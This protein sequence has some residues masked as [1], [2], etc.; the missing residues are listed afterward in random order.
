MRLSQVTGTVR[1][2]SQEFQHNLLR[3]LVYLQISS[4]DSPEGEL[5]AQVSLKN[6]RCANHP[7]TAPP[8]KPAPGSCLSEGQHYLN[9]EVWKPDYDQTCT[10]CTC[11]VSKYLKNNKICNNSG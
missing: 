5:R 7:T 8:V 9:G 4:E 11:M 1:D 10:T 2:L 3:G 6:N